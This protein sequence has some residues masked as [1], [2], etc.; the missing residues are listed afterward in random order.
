MFEFNSKTYVKRQFKM[1]ELYKQMAA[2]KDTKADSKVISHIV[3]TNVLS[4]DT[5]NYRTKGNV[6]EIYM[7]EVVLNE[8][9][10][11]TLFI[12]GLDK[13]INF[14]T[15]F[16]FKY[17]DERM[18]YGAYKEK[19]EKGFR[20][21]KYYGTDWAKD[22]KNI[23][24]PVTVSSLDSLYVAIFD[25][26]IPID[27]RQDETTLELITR[28]ERTVKLRR[29]I[30]KQQKIVDNEKQP[31]QRFEENELLKEMQKELREIG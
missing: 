27:A 22:D 7:F 23:E 24:I 3:L 21:T 18:L 13:A 20:F 8:K 17:N 11:P 1:S 19:G 12:S 6:K 15:F 5:M 26:L 31:K 28:Y 29:E 4:N 30:E 9:R 2:N 14:Q 25:V 16:I 10:I